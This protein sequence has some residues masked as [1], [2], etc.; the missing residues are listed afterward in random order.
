MFVFGFLTVI[1]VKNFLKVHNTEKCVFCS[2]HFVSINSHYD[3]ILE[4]SAGQDMVWNGLK[5]TR[6]WMHKQ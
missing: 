4:F 6:N 1:S 2:I 5:L 3:F